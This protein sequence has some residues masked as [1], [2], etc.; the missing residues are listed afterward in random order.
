MLYFQDA[1]YKKA[2]QESANKCNKEMRK[3]KSK[4]DPSDKY[5][6]T[7]RKERAVYGSKKN[8]KTN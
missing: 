3:Q 1:L 8:D 4:N 2:L 5:E 7:N 6:K